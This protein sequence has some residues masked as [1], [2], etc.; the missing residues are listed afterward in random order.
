M[1]QPQSQ[2]AR[3]VAKPVLS[4]AQVLALGARAWDDQE[5][6][7]VRLSQIEDPIIRQMAATVAGY[8]FGRMNNAC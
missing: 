1:N 8:V 7:V 4:D 5:T 3:Y 2:L 6:L